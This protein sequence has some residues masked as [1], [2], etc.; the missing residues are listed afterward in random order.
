MVDGSTEG[1]ALPTVRP[2]LSKWSWVEIARGVP[3]CH[4]GDL[5]PV[6]TFDIAE[7]RSGKE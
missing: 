3:G 4:G 1:T 2:L 5:W 6:R 7:E